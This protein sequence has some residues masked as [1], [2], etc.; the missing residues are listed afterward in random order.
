MFTILKQTINCL[1]VTKDEIEEVLKVVC[2]SHNLA[3]A[4]VWILYEDEYSVPFSYSLED[5]QTK[6]LLAIKLT[7]HLYAV[8]EHEYNDFEPYFRFGDVM[9]HAIG[10]EFP[11]VTLQDY[12]SRYMS[13][14]HSDMHINWDNDLC[15]S[16]ALAIC[17]RSNDTADFNYA[18]EFIWTKQSNY[19]ILLEAILLTLKRCLPRFKFA[20]GAE[21]GDELDVIL[22]DSSTDDETQMFKIFQEKRSS[23]MPTTPK[24]AKNPMVVDLITPSKVTCKTAPKVLPR[25]VIENQFGKTMKDAAKDLNGK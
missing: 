25:E 10:E 4:Q 13:K 20:S 11:F 17:L 23:T 21:L 22:V 15:P 7:G 16:S 1:Q 14:L 3:L 18:F 19:V 8:A 6:R 24:K 5:T 9:P 12:E 2:E